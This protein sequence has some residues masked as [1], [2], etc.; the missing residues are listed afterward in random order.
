M[1]GSGVDVPKPLVPVAGVPLV[2]RN[3]RALVAHGFADLAVATPA[4]GPVAE[5]AEARLA[6]V[7]SEAGARLRVVRERVPLGNIGC[8]GALH[9]EGDVLVVYADNLTALDL[10]D[11]VRYHA[12][13]GA[14]LTLAAHDEE[15]RLPYGR[16]DVHGARVVGY[17][18]KP[19]TTVTI[20]SGVAVLGRDA[21]AL[22]PDDRPTGLVDLT[23]EL[24]G[25][26][27]HV[28][29]YRHDAPWVDVNDADGVQRAERLLAEHPQAFDTALRART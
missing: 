2:E 22:L 19:V 27:L 17:A 8:A 16:L 10:A 23:R 28:A 3:V 20:A 24:L 7:A 29:A 13:S 6:A 14:A 5:F 15:L 12:A 1:R 4:A 25:R 26:G 9:G 18:E 11:V 21:T